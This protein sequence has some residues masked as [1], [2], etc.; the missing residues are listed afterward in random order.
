[1]PYT[2]LADEQHTERD[3]SPTWSRK[4]EFASRKLEAGNERPE[5]RSGK[6]EAGRG[7]ILNFTHMGNVFGATSHS[8]QSG[9]L[10]GASFLRHIKLG[11]DNSSWT[12]RILKKKFYLP[13]CSAT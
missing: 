7:G 13:Y 3:E 8:A 9:R 10:D 4:P 6:Q 12:I 5:T 11:D 1:M 2:I